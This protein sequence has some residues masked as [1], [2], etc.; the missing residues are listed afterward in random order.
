MEVTPYPGHG[1]KRAGAGRKP[2]L[3][4]QL[5]RAEELAKQ[6][7]LQVKSGLSTLAEKYPEIVTTLVREALGEDETGAKIKKPNLQ[8]AMKLFEQGVKLA[9]IS[10]ESGNRDFM[11]TIERIANSGGTVN[12]DNRVGASADDSAG[13]PGPGDDG[14][15]VEGRV[16]R[17]E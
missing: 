15:T 3:A 12:I 8:V 17:V 1:G 13:G 5:K 2:V 11:R 4:N 14:R 9:E 6:L 7:N 16:V 10:E